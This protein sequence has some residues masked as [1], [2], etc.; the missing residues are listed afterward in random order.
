M[1]IR[2][3]TAYVIDLE[4]TCSKDDAPQYKVQEIIE[5]GIVAIDLIGRNVKKNKLSILVKNEVTPISEYCTDLTGITQEI[6]DNKGVPFSHALAQ[7]EEFICKHP[8]CGAWGNFDHVLMIKQ[9]ERLGLQNPL[10]HTNYNLKNLHAISRGLK[11]E[12][13]LMN[14][15]SYEGM[16]FKGIQ[17]R[18]CDDAENA[19]EVWLKLLNATLR[20]D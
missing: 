17:H 16:Q 9:C 18:A 8:V 5:I 1:R 20:K 12:L 11:K 7:I 2:T 19:A 4:A 6:L 10:N 15:L 3:H 13:G 14:A